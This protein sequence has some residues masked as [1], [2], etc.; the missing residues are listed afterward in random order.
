MELNDLLETFRQ[1]ANSER[2]K[3]DYFERLVRVFI[4]N[5]DTQKQFY[6]AVVPFA[7]WAEANGWNKND[8][9]IDL[10]G[11]LADGSGYA[12]IQCKFYALGYSIQ[13][14]D[15]DSF[16]SA[17]SNDVFS[18]LV[19]ADTTRKDFS[20]NAL[21]MLDKLSKD[22]N[23]IGISE[24]ENSRIDW[25]QFIRPGNISLAPKKTLRDHQRTGFSNVRP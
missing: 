10:V 8:I 22:W 13:K 20:R 5:D 23:R 24:L 21:E 14:A 2:E 3:G 18:R 6:S 12:A 17:A 11:T 25:S 19:I 16:V 1:G 7:H 9:G 4:E 15:L